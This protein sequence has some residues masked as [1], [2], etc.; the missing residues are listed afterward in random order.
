MDPVKPWLLAA[1]YWLL[2]KFGQALLRSLR[3]V[4]LGWLVSPQM[5]LPWLL[6]SQVAI[7]ALP[8]GSV[9]DGNL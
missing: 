8:S 7:L 6:H 9:L 1:N 2:P 5:S 4:H 3:G